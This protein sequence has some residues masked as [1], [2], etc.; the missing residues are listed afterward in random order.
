M[1]VRVKQFLGREVLATVLSV[2]WVIAM[3][4]ACDTAAAQQQSPPK[5]SAAQQS[6][7]PKGKAFIS[8]EEAAAALHTAARNNDE[9]A[10]IVILGPGASEMITWSPDPKEREADRQVFA[11]KYD[12]MHRLVKE[13]DG[14]VAL[15]VGAENWPLPIPLVEVN[16]AWYFDTDL[17]QKE[18]LYRRIGKNEVEAVEVC[19]ALVD[20]EKEYYASAHQYTQKFVSAE[21]TH[22]GLYW[23]STNNGSRSPIGP[24]LAHAG[25]SG[26]QS[27]NAVPF[28]G[29]Y[30]RILSASTGASSNTQSHAGDAKAMQGFAVVAFPAE[31]RSSGVMTFIVDN[32]GTA[33]QKDLGPMTPTLAKQIGSIDP[34][35]TWAKV[36]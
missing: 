10:L 5:Q 24:F 4:F 30:Y 11:R 36:E 20:A 13:P 31:Y 35:N 14:T 15:Y 29:Y 27:T 17:G 9:S 23:A 16:G 1:S 33:R 26:G 21:G 32:K 18:V 3:G 12:Q 25:V 28:H 22:D 7:H 6:T 34:D 19:N 2:C 8:P